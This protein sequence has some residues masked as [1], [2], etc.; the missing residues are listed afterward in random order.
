VLDERDADAELRD[1][2]RELLGAVEGI[3]HPDP[4]ALQAVRRVGSLWI[5]PLT[6]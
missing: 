6:I 3:D 5:Y 4:R 2:L 1:L